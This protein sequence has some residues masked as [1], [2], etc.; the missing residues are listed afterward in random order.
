MPV[1]CREVL[2]VEIDLAE[3]VIAFRD[4]VG[5]I[6]HAHAFQAGDLRRS[7]RA[8]AI[9]ADRVGPGTS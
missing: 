2:E 1:G 4:D 8:D 7:G 5:A 3:E 6:V 9:I